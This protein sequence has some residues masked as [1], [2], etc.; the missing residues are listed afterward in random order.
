MVL[1][2][3]NAQTWNCGA[4]GNN[5]TATLSGSSPNYT[6]TI[7]G[8]GDMAYYNGSNMPWFS[9]KLQMKYLVIGD[10]VTSIGNHAFYGCNRLTGSLIIPDLVTTIGGYAFEGCSGFTGDLII[11]NS[12]TSIGGYAFYE[13]NKFTGDLIIPNSV[14]TIGNGAFS[15][16]TGFTNLTIGSSVT[17]IGDAAFRGCSGL[18]SITSLNPTPPICA[19]TLGIVSV[20]SG[21]PTNIP[22]YVPCGTLYGIKSGWKDFTNYHSTDSNL[23]PVVVISGTCGAQGNNLTW[24]L[25]CDGTITISG[26]GDMEDYDYYGHTPWYS[27]ENVIKNVVI[28]DNVTHIGNQA[29]SRLHNLVSVTIP[30]NVKS[31]GYWAFSECGYLQ[32]VNFNAI[33][34]AM[35]CV[36][37]DCHKVFEFCGTQTNATVNIG[38]KVDT[39]PNGAFWDFRGLTTVNIPNGVTAIGHSAF[40]DCDSMKNIDIPETVTYIGIRAF[41]NCFGLTSITIPENV[42]YVGDCAFLMGYYGGTYISS[43]HTVNF[44]AINCTYLGGF[45]GGQAWTNCHNVT[46]LNIGNKVTNI[47]ACAFYGL[48]DDYYGTSGGLKS[49]N[50]PNSVKNIGWYAFGRCKKLETI[51]IPNSVDSI[52]WY[53][54]AENYRLTSITIPANVKWIG[55]YVFEENINMTS[56]NVESENEFYCSQDGVLFNKDKSILICCPGGKTGDYIIPN[57][58][59]T[60]EKGSFYG[61][62]S[63]KSVNIPASVTSIGGWAFRWMTKNWDPETW[64]YIDP[65]IT[66]LKTVTNLNPVPID[67]S[68]SIYENQFGETDISLCTLRVPTSSVSA[69][70]AA[71]IWQNFIIEG[72]G[73][74]VNP[75]AN[76]AKFGSVT[77]DGLYLQNETATV[78]ATAKTNC[79]FIN[80]TKN[81]AVV[82]TNPTYSFTVTEDIEL[83]ANFGGTPTGIDNY[84]T[85]SGISVFPNPTNGI[86]TITAVG[87]GF[88]PAQ[89]GASIQIYDISGR[90]V[91]GWTYAIRP[92]NNE[93]TLDISHLQQ[94]MYYLRVG[95]ETIKIIKN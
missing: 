10:S 36:E 74:L 38:N 58:V 53:A 17:N 67:L 63:L 48:G 37:T 28:G 24:Q 81:G 78:T 26:S 35:G 82:S 33:N 3:V 5:L 34:C 79:W 73:I 44:N 47:P 22:V 21:V 23:A 86:I 31:I 54:F 4:Q 51:T 32:T 69:Y 83:V 14:T 30:E 65:P 56:I 50:I 2:S 40:S 19:S 8:S 59:T 87:A 70:Q 20:F 39:I 55:N 75:H 18:K 6:L 92:N 90:V 77:G 43:L 46:T 72:G 45:Y 57:T 12:V 11:S 84:K 15:K 94:G 9:Y 91:D 52:A 25:T 62:Q 95:N 76:N 61:C 71:P 60:I 89:N 80:W 42:T 93:F 66:N 27:Y 64:E 1:N 7:S 13:C 68:Y 49:I 88:T 85:N 16:C 29:F 41:H